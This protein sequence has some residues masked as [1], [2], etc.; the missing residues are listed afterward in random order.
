MVAKDVAATHVNRGVI[1]DIMGQYP[2]AYRDFNR[3]IAYNPDLGDGYLN[4]SVALTRMK[5]LDEALADVQKAIA[6]GVSEPE[7]GYYDRAVVYENL[8]RFTEAYYDY[9]K[10]LELAPGYEPASEA[11]KHFVVTRT[12]KKAPGDGT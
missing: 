6:L 10:A 4:R 3:S 11:L 8:G 12:P 5:R 9:K 2:E 1:L 7:I